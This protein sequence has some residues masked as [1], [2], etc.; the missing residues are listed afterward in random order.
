MGNDMR[1]RRILSLL[2]CASAFLGSTA[3]SAGA[4]ET[5]VVTE[6]KIN[7]RGKPGF[8]GEVVTQLDRG[9]KVTI[10]ERVNLDRAKPGEPTNWA[11]IKLP[12]NT[13]GWVFAPFIKEGRVSATRLNLRAGPGENYSVIGRL[14]R[15]ESIKAIRTVEEWIE[16]E[17]PED[18]YAFVDLSTLQIEGSNAPAAPPIIAAVPAAPPSQPAVQPET[19]TSQPPATETPATAATTNV[20]SNL[21]ESAPTAAVPVT[22]ET[23]EKP[24]EVAAPSTEVVPQTPDVAAEVPKETSAPEPAV[25]TE[26]ATPAVSTATNEVAAVETPPVEAPSQ[27]QPETTPATPAPAEPA[28]L[29]MPKKSGEQARRIVRREGVIRPTKSIQAPTWYE[30]VNAETGK[31]INYLYEEKLGVKL[32]DYR[33]QKVVVSGEEAIDQRWPNTPIL[34]LETLDVLP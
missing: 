1:I 16:I 29:I 2:L 25:S 21:P 28:P 14:K 18:S 22:S 30:L 23:S 9:D 20:A 13:P 26:P 31:T 33:G 8:I 5:A 15:G 32:K 11:K 27:P 6:G 10:L 12:E 19:Q 7:V 34:D 4:E 24:P 3:D 17:A